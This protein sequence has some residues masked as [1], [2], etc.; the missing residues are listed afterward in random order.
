MLLCYK[1]CTQASLYLSLNENQKFM[2]LMFLSNIDIFQGFVSKLE[3][4]R[5]DNAILRPISDGK[6]ISED[7]LPP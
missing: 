5:T 1:H 7:H 3:I 4:L 2:P 6:Q